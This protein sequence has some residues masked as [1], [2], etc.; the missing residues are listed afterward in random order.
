MIDR[1]SASLVFLL[2]LS[3]SLPLV[4]ATGH[5]ET[6]TSS[7][8]GSP[9]ELHVE[10]V[11]SVIDAD[12]SQFV[13]CLVLDSGTV[14]CWGM[15]NE[16]ML[17]QGDDARR[18]DMNG[19]IDRNLTPVSLPS[20]FFPVGVTTGKSNVCVRSSVGS[21]ICW[22]A[23][24]GIVGPRYTT[25]GDE[26]DDM[27]E[28]LYIITIPGQQI[29]DIAIAH[30]TACALLDDGSVICWG[31]N[32][33]GV[34][35]GGTSSQA[36]DEPHLG[37]I[38]DLGTDRTAVVLDGDGNTMCAVLDNGDVKCWGENTNG[39]LGQ[40][41]TLHRGDADGELGDTLL[42]VDLGTA[43]TATDIA[44]ST[45]HVCALLDDGTIRCW[46]DS[47]SGRLGN[48]E[49]GVVGDQVGEMGDSLTVTSI[50]STSQ[51]V[52]IFATSTGTCALLS[53]G[54]VKCWGNNNY[55]NLGYESPSVLGDSLSEMGD[56]LP[57]LDLGSG[58]VVDLILGDYAACAVYAEGQMRCWGSNLYGNVGRMYATT[59]SGKSASTMGALLPDIGQV[60]E[61]TVPLYSD[62]QADFNIKN[63]TGASATIT[64]VQGSLP[65]GM[66]V[67]GTQM[68]GIISD[69][70]AIGQ[71]NV[72]FRLEQG[73]LTSHL[74]LTIDVVDTPLLGAT[75]PGAFTPFISISAGDMVACGVSTQSD[76]FCWGSAQY[77]MLAQ[78]SLDKVGLGGP[79][80]GLELQPISLPGATTNVSVGKKH[81]CAISGAN[82]YC[83]GHPQY[84]RLGNGMSSTTQIFGDEPGEV[85]DSM[86]PVDL[87]TSFTPVSVAVGEHHTC[88]LSDTGNVRCFGWG[89][90]GRLGTGST[91]THGDT[92][93]EMGDGLTDI[94]LGTGFISAGISAS[95]FGSCA[96]S[97]AGDVKCW[98][99]GGSGML[100]QGDS[101]NIGDA[102]SEMGD[103]L[104]PIDLGTGMKVEKVSM[105]YNHVC[106][107]LRTGAVKCWGQ[108][109]EGQL[110]LGDKTA[111]GMVLG[112]MGDSLPQVDLSGQVAIDVAAGYKTTCAALVNGDSVCWGHGVKN[113]LGNS[114]ST[115]IGD[116]SGEMGSALIP[117]AVP[118]GTASSTLNLGHTFGCMVT[119]AS[120]GRCWGTNTEGQ[121][122][123]GDRFGRGST[124]E[125]S[126]ADPIIVG[127]LIA[128]R[129][130]RWA[131]QTYEFSSVGGDGTNFAL[132]L[133]GGSLPDGWS[134]SG[135]NLSGSSDEEATTMVTLSLIDGHHTTEQ[136]LAVL[137]FP[138][139]LADIDY[140]TL[141]IEA[142][143]STPLAIDPPVIT[144]GNTSA[145]FFTISPQ[146]PAG[147]EFNSADGSITGTVLS[148][149]PDTEYTVTAIDPTDIVDGAAHSIQTTF[150]LVGLNDT[151][152]DGVPDLR[153]SDDDDDG[154][155]DSVEIGCGS[156]PLDQS[157]VTP[158]T[159]GDG[160]CDPLD[161]DDDND[162]VNDVED[163]FPL[164]R[165]ET[166]DF[167][168]DGQGD[169]SD[170][171]DDGDGWND[172]DEIYCQTNPLNTSSYPPDLDGDHSCD[173][174]DDDDDGDNV[175][176][177]QDLFP[178]DA[179]EWEDSDLD[180]IGDN[181]DPDD[182]NDGWNDTDENGCSSNPYDS[183]SLP[184]DLDG[185]HLCD[186]IDPDEDNDGYDVE[187]ETV[188]G[189]DLRDNTSTPPDIDGDMICD[190]LDH[191]RDG[192]GWN[193][194]L[195]VD[196]LTD[197][198][199]STSIPMD[200]D[201]DGICRALEED[202]DGDGIIDQDE[203]LCGT[204]ANDS[205]FRP[206]DSDRDGI[207]DC[208]DDETVTKK[209]TSSGGG[210]SGSSRSSRSTTEESGGFLPSPSILFTL[211]STIVISLT[212][213][214]VPTQRITVPCTR[215]Q[216]YQTD[217]E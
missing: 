57:A 123:L 27:G 200:L 129:L 29:E 7:R 19:E 208:V 37:D 201:G 14:R 131:S 165:N 76:L 15:E 140:G 125:L 105:G 156:D 158:D 135:T 65:A 133:S 90:H 202:T 33:N 77:G 171:D 196:C 101:E 47:T 73:G 66:S 10:G 168:N 86:A 1:T 175:S 91:Q 36:I 98:G 16:G 34:R 79:N 130:P 68:I 6:T 209:S 110:G 124:D 134:I 215:S 151:D 198:N 141:L 103:T 210:D 59:E 62:I 172:T 188:C 30:S 169:N 119:T 194:S 107:L 106:A 204:D 174:L 190:D 146:L 48:G 153:D 64:V 61:L 184:P 132:A 193:N 55:G 60:N 157:D 40:G 45:K 28:Q 177:S 13:T 178:R 114:L 122:G 195:E 144:G 143:R 20:S 78:G 167:D 180:G 197:G 25:V 97:T 118:E 94:D 21:A 191:D 31:G 85:S 87:G 50:S 104:S 32:I 121:L 67:Q 92:P 162:G 160:E 182:D 112:Q 128:V 71:H 186:G 8:Q 12:M 89:F 17:G 69:K 164:D 41:D 63:D 116:Q 152:S 102:P 80:T 74:N 213:R 138:N 212:R 115:N 139:P 88:A 147:L 192:D 84:G 113:A 205:N 189:S 111:R 46:G 185:D 217:V 159:D 93:A 39:L 207:A 150:H 5:V 214:G 51:P 136:R 166:A 22:G 56:S 23:A 170:V 95:D 42:K 72:E 18:G 203:L 181:G 11:G 148:F 155:T 96:W 43:R 70:T 137:V 206:V 44:V 24:N 108:N 109:T 49:S 54:N 127:D 120:H 117:I 154:V 173:S 99:Y 161:D 176:D 142:L 75:F 26:S 82:L 81:V 3:T 35:G 149:S 2:L 83:W 211:I 100:G 187:N 183:T 52:D 9:I 53:D 179:T 4:Q 163:S 216:E 38:I 199:D 126:S 145:L 58:E